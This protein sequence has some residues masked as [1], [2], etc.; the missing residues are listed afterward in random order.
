MPI[1][2][3]KVAPRSTR[4]SRRR[5]LRNGPRL[6]FEAFGPIETLADSVR[7]AARRMAERK[8]PAI[9]PGWRASCPVW[10]R[11]WDGATSAR[12]RV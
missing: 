1:C 12:K 8:P 6:G 3:R 7:S 2:R 11:Q 9:G 10:L 4:K 5:D